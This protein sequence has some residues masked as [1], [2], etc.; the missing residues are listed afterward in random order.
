MRSFDPCQRYWIKLIGSIV[1]TG[2]SYARVS[3]REP[4]PGVEPGVTLERYYALNWL[5]GY[6]EQE[7]DDISTDT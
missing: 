7:R 5:I 2:R 3:G 6:M 1:I 4:L